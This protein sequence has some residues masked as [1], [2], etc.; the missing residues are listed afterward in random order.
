ME[1]ITKAIEEKFKKFPLYSQ[2][3]KNEKVIVVKYFLGGWTWY[4]TEGSQQGDDFIMFGYVI[5]GLGEDCNEWG[6]I[7]MNELKSLRGAF[8][9][10]VE[11]DLYFGEHTIN[12]KGEVK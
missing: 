12:L 6:Y 11:R 3:N 7:S 4:I 10:G 8:G 5:S 1:L 9:L 2:E